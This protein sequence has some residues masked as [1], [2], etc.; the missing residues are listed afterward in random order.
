MHLNFLLY[1]DV[2]FELVVRLLFFLC[3]ACCSPMLFDLAVLLPALVSGTSEDVATG[4][5]DSSLVELL[6]FLLL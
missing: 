6:I 1:F 2:L 5:V 3:I 4:P